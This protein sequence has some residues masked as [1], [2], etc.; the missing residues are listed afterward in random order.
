MRLRSFGP[1]VLLVLLL[2]AAV[3][4]VPA[5]HW[6]RLVL[7]TVVLWAATLPFAR[8]RPRIGAQVAAGGFFL[9]LLALGVLWRRPTSP[10]DAL[11]LHL[12]HASVTLSRAALILAA[13]FLAFVT[14]FR[15]PQKGNR[16]YVAHQ[17]PRAMQD[18]LSCYFQGV[19]PLLA[20]AL[21]SLN[22]RFVE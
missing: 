10:A 7:A 8:V 9:F 17:S 19:Q 4:S 13:F 22:A 14:M 18:C 5:G 16:A 1:Y 3:A 6:F 21:T 11:P 15:D 20:I 12:S 2:V